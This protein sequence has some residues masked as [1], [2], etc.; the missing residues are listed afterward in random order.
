MGVGSEGEVRKV[1][2]SILQHALCAATHVLD[3]LQEEWMEVAQ[4]RAF[5]K[6]HS[7]LKLQRWW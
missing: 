3:L 1:V 5:T 7:Q 6:H 2:M 4:C